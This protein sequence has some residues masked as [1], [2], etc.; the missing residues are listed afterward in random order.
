MTIEYIDRADAL[1]DEVQKVDIG[2]GQGCWML[3]QGE[4]TCSAR[5]CCDVSMRLW[6]HATVMGSRLS[7][8]TAVARHCQQVLDLAEDG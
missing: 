1:E 8:P 2:R 4:I 5:Y 3:T 7:Q 6:W